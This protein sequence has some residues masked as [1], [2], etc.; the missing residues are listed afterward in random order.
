MTDE[1]LIYVLAIGVFRL[2]YAAGTL[3]KSMIESLS[4]SVIRRLTRKSLEP[5]TDARFKQLYQNVV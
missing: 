4:L 1:H 2:H 3:I 5:K